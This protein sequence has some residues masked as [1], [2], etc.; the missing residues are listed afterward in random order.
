M[1]VRMQTHHGHAAGQVLEYRLKI[2]LQPVFF[3]LGAHGPR[4]VPDVFH[5][6]RDAVPN[7]LPEAGAVE[8]VSNHHLVVDAIRRVALQRAEL[9]GRSASVKGRIAFLT[10]ADLT[11]AEQPPGFVDVEQVV[12]FTV[13][14][15]DTVRRFVGDALKQAGLRRHAGKDRIKAD[16]FGQRVQP[17][18][19]EMEPDQ[20][21][22]F[23]AH[24]IGDIQQLAVFQR[25]PGG[26]Q[27]PGTVGF[28]DCAQ[29]IR[30]DH[31]RKF[32]TRVPGERG[33]AV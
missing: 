28:K 4:N 21:A 22:V 17:A 12:I 10:D 27:D 11:A 3:P 1:P 15:V 25:V 19:V 24:P 5:V 23:V 18:C 32:F 16:A 30:P 31:C 7:G 29:G 2:L 6:G 20:L 33:D 9:T 14:D 26:G 13:D 8:P